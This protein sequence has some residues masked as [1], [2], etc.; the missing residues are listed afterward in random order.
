MLHKTLF[1]RADG[2]YNNSKYNI[3]KKQC[4]LTDTFICKRSQS[5]KKLKGLI[6]K[7]TTPEHPRPLLLPP[8]APKQPFPP[9]LT[10]IPSSPSSP[11]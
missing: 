1:D 5:A 2:R 6:K 3:C 10:T 11:Q 7:K 4:F 9:C 8:F